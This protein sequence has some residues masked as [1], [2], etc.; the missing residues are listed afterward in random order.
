MHSISSVT[1]KQTKLPNLVCTFPISTSIDSYSSI[2]LHHFISHGRK[3]TSLLCHKTQIFWRYCASQIISQDTCQIIAKNPQ[4]FKYHKISPIYSGVHKCWP[5]FF[6]NI[7]EKPSIQQ[8]KMIPYMNWL[9][10]PQ[11]WSK[12]QNGRLKKPHF[13]APPILNIFSWNFHGLVLGLVEFVDKKGIALAQLIWLWG[14][15]T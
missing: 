11:R 1:N 4:K 9:L 6:S 10:F 15:L 3:E 14:C 13:P 5:S 12:N 8:K 2:W 7:L